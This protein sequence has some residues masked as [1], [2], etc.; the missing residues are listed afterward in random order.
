MYQAISAENQVQWRGLGWGGVGW[1]SKNESCSKWPATHF[2][3]ENFE[4]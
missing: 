3:F 1:G 2:G 4:I